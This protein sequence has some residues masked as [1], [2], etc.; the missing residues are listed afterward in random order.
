V[1]PKTITIVQGTRVTFINNDRL[2]HDV[3]SDP[4]PEHTD[5]PDIN[6]VGF[7]VPGQTKLTG[8]MNVVR[9]CGYHDHQEPDVT[10]LQGTIIIV[11][12]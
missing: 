4:H 12:Q 7:I 5:C 1:S 9:R 6:Q 10:N 2:S 8:N 11:S 3:E